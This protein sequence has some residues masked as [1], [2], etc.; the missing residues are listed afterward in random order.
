MTNARIGI[1]MFVVA[2]LFFLA[3]LAN[4]RSS[5]VYIAVGVVFLTLSI[6]FNKKK[7]EK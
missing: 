5:A 2:V 6:I 3:A 4:A 1:L 7:S